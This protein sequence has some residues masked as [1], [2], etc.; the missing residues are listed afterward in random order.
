MTTLP[1]PPPAGRGPN[2]PDPRFAHLPP[3]PVGAAGTRPDLL[4]PMPLPPPLSK[5]WWATGPILVL[6]VA[7]MIFVLGR[8][9]PYVAFTPGSARSVE[10][11][12]SVQQQGDGP[13]PQLEAPDGDLLFVTVS[14]RRPSGI[15]A[16]YRHAFDDTNEVVPSK[17]VDGN[18]SREENRSFNLQ[19]MTDSKDKATKV[20]LERAGF[21]VE[22]RTDGAV[23]VDLDPTYPVAAVIQPGD[24]IVG[25]DGAA[26]TDA[27]DL[28]AVIAER[29]PGDVVALEVQGFGAAETRS[30]QAEL[31]TNPETGAA[32][33]GVSLDDRPEYVFPV[34]VDI[35]SGQVGGPS[36][37]LAFTLA[38]LDRLTPGSLTG[39]QRVA[40]TGT[41]DLDA[42]VGPVGGVVQKTEAAIDAGAEIFLVPPDEFADATA[43]ARGRLAV[44]QV[45]SLDEA[46]AA[47]EELGGDPVA[48]VAPAAD[49]D[50]TGAGG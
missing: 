42:S 14:L 13:V 10:P 17:L 31:A 39:D 20:A 40:V 30:V 5:L 16:L 8:P 11:L 47:L 44:R 41:I 43:A 6:L 9:A 37:G 50:G 38:L 15:E 7:S 24:T 33:L 48:D 1:P 23:V 45:A 25:A 32:Q 35:D 3:P 19:L 22:V 27:D 36:A 4:G 26:V 49:P 21:E 2:G 18:Q 28:V 29:E 46:L 34:R 12:I